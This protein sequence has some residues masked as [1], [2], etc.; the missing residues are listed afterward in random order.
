[1][2]LIQRI[3][4]VVNAIAQ[5]IKQLRLDVNQNNGLLP[6]FSSPPSNKPVGSQWLEEYNTQ[7]GEVIGLGLLFTY[8]ESITLEGSYNIQGTSSIIKI[9]NNG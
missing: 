6:I 4:D 2:V 5:D 1:M 3:I 7:D 8:N 9:I